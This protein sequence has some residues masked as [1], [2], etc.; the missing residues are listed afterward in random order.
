MFEEVED[1]DAIVVL[2]GGG[3]LIS[4]IS[5]ASK[6]MHPQTKIIAVS[7]QGAPAMKNPFEAKKALDTLSVRT[8]ADGIAVRDTSSITLEY[9]LKNVDVF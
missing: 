5:V 1:L 8:I 7:A 2:V 6:A 3:G 4:G 9:I